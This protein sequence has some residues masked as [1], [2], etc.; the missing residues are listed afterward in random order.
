MQNFLLS[1]RQMAALSLTGS[2]SEG[3][4]ISIRSES[5][6]T[7]K[8]LK[9]GRQATLSAR[10]APPGAMPESARRRAFRTRVALVHTEIV[11]SNSQNL[12]ALVCVS[13]S[14]TT[15][16]GHLMSSLRAAKE[17]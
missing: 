11:H 3:S 14:R 10:R 7:K 15:T 13:G 12:H 5:L 17:H 9:A 16:C 6:G 2:R 8:H 4:V 1:F